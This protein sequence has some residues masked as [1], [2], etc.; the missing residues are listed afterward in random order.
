MSDTSIG[1]GMP[2]V[3]LA[4]TTVT[5]V[6]DAVSFL[7]LGHVFTA[8]MTGNVVFLGFAFAGAPGLSIPH[9]SLSL[10]AF[11]LGALL[12]GRMVAKADSNSGRWMSRA[13]FWETLFLLA[14]MAGS[15]GLTT[16]S[17]A[18]NS[19]VEIVIAFSA[20]AMGLRNAV[21]RKLAVADLTTTVLTL[22]ITGLAADSRLAN[23]N[24]P[25]WQRRFAAVL[26]M[27]VGAAVGAL[28]IDRS[29]ALPLAICV[30]ASA[31]CALASSRIE[32][33]RKT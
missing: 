6:V 7:A 4:A 12:G 28:C 29:I 18:Y 22:T 15:I 17:E 24:N 10:V 25:R 9:S 14:A 3:L 11:A 32:S 30:A 5:G 8:N 33:R 31:A 21:V 23:G 16:Q 27:L 2:L 20:L 19:Q 13:F 26:S 1:T